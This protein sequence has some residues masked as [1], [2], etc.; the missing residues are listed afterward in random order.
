MTPFKIKNIFRDPFNEKNMNYRIQLIF[1]MAQ[2]I[3]SEGIEFKRK[4]RLYKFPKEQQL[5][6]NNLAHFDILAFSQRDGDYSYGNKNS[7]LARFKNILFLNSYLQS[8]ILNPPIEFDLI[9]KD[10]GGYAAP[11]IQEQLNT[12]INYNINDLYYTH[13]LFL[14]D[15]KYSNHIQSRFL[16]FKGYPFEKF[17]FTQSLGLNDPKLGITYFEEHL[18]LRSE[19]NKNEKTITFKDIIKLHSY[20]KSLP[21]YENFFKDFSYG[22][23][24]K[25][26]NHPF[27]NVNLTF[28]QGGIHSELLNDGFL[29]F[30]SDESLSY[31]DFDVLSYYVEILKQVF[32]K[33]GKQEWSDLLIQ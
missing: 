9:N 11:V 21:V 29:F 31:Y 19:I 12:W 4:T 8:N 13:H 1:Q 17:T 2:R 16:F 5:I 18:K 24:S 30:K 7:S 27:K 28:S 20:E 6:E 25:K 14:S 3:I 22:I 33:S 26:F 15:K 10:K 32:S 23:E